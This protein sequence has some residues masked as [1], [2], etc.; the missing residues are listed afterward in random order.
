MEHLPAKKVRKRIQRH[1][2]TLSRDADIELKLTSLPAT[3]SPFGLFGGAKPAEK[4][5]ETPVSTTEKDA[6]GR[7]FLQLDFL[8]RTS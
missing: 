6:T 2:V 8:Q 3:L 1:Q 7:P 5:E 4:K